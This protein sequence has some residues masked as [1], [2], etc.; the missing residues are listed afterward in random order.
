MIYKHSLMAGISNLD[1]ILKILVY[2]VVFMLIA[3]ALFTAI[4]VPIYHSIGESFDLSNRM[5]VLHKKLASTRITI[6]GVDETYKDVKQFFEQDAQKIGAALGV[7]ITF[8]MFILFFTSLMLVPATVLMHQ[9]MTTGFST[10]FTKALIGNLK[11]SLQFAFINTI[12]GLILN[13][14]LGV[15]LYYITFTLYLGLKVVGLSIAVLIVSFMQGLKSVLI[16]QW[17]PNIVIE[18]KGILKSLGNS[19]KVSYKLM[20]DLLPFFTFLILIVIT[21]SLATSVFTAYLMPIL[22]FSLFG[23]F[24]ISANIISYYRTNKQNYMINEQ[25]FTFDDL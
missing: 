12:L 24:L 13:F 1:L 16:S 3:M 15:I 14:A 11:Q 23:I 25:R 17:L 9:R 6:N 20:S 19:V 2:I 21:V 7:Y 10:S 4:A 18:K 8:F 22:I 5:D